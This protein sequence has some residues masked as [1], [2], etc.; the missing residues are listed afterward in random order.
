MRNKLAIF[1]LDGTLFDTG[2][3]NYMSYAK[4]LSEFGVSIEEDYYINHCNGRHYTVFLPKLLED[5]KKIKRVHDHKKE[6]YASNLKYARENVILF[7]MINAIKKDYYIALVTTANAK[8][9]SDI[10]EFFGH[11][12]DFDLILT[13]EN[14]DKQKPDP[15]GFLKAIEHFGISSQNTYIF[16]DS[17]VGLIAAKATGANVMKVEKWSD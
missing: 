15:E 11:D 4:A 10:L 2:R 13:Q 3:V 14:I 8:N 5:E 16:E 17:E 9:T 1:D 7:D 6:L 12:N